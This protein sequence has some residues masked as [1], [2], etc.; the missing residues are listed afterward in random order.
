M[1]GRCPTPRRLSWQSMKADFDQFDVLALWTFWQA[2]ADSEDP[3]PSRLVAFEK[4]AKWK[5]VVM[6][7]DREISRRN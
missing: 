2:E 7:I 4:A 3:I 6:E 5:A 1:P